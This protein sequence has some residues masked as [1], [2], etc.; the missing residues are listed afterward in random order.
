MVAAVLERIVDS[1]QNFPSLPSAS[2]PC[3]LHARTIKN[4]ASSCSESA[5]PPTTYH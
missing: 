1:F 2:M 4:A 5:F 3:L